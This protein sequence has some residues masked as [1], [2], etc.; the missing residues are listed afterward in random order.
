MSKFIQI[1]IRL[2]PEYGSR[3]L[4]GPFPRLAKFLKEHGYVRVLEEEPDLYHMAEVLVRIRNDPAVPEGDKKPVTD[5][6]EKIQNV[7][8]EAREHLLGR[9]LNE[10]DQS[11]YKLEDLFQDLEK[12]LG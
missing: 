2:I 1:D 8:R 9:R 4:A 11:L 12:D 7:Q 10:L 3:G 6:L 5:M